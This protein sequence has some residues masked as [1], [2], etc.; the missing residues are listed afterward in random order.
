MCVLSVELRLKALPHWLH[1]CG[2]SCG[3]G[4]V[5]REAEAPAG[6]SHLGCSW[7]GHPEGT[8][9]PGGG[10]L[11]DPLVILSPT[12]SLSLR[13]LG[14]GRVGPGGHVPGCG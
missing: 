8:G 10:L 1:L 4:R 13:V 3:E 12:P 6:R 7:K 14:T 11:G 2:F 9:A 5:H